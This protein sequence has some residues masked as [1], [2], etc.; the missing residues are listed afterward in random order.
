MSWL[1]TIPPKVA[2]GLVLLA[3]AVVVGLGLRSAPSSANGGA[4]ALAI[5]TRLLAPCCW[6]GTLD[7]HDSELARSLRSEI[8]TRVAHGEAGESIE[9]DLVERYGPKI[10]ALPHE[11]ALKMML[12]GAA[13]LVLGAGLFLFTRVRKWRRSSEAEPAR[14][15][16]QSPPASREHDRYDARIDAELAEL[17]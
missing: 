5:K 13:V 7:T 2:Y 14:D 3:L 11:E 4:G 17:D 6:N 15:G 8:D 10:R 16:D 1:P 9:A 12:G